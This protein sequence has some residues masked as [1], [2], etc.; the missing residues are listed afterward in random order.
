MYSFGYGLSYTEFSYDSLA[1]EVVGKNHVRVKVGVTNTGRMDGDEVVQ[2][3]VTDPVASTVRP[4]RQL[5]AFERVFAHQGQDHHKAELQRPCYDGSQ[6]RTA[7]LEPWQ[8]EVAEY[9]AVVEHHVRDEGR[10]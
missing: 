3:Y 1:C 5:R 10:K 6:S 7:H 9:Q 4:C 8:A 2:V